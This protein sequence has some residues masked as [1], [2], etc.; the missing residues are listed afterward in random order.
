MDSNGTGTGWQGCAARAA[1]RAGHHVLECA[2]VKVVTHS[3]TN[4]DT[5]GAKPS[6]V[7]GLAVTFSG[8]SYSASSILVGGSRGPVK[9][10]GVGAFGALPGTALQQ[11]RNGVQYGRRCRDG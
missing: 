11:L 3:S 5:L 2:S 6:K 10:E 8:S 1:G 9:G 4:A 7:S